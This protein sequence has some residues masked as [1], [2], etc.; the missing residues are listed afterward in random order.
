MAIACADNG[1]NT[2]R[3]TLLPR[4]FGVGSNEDAAEGGEDGA[5]GGMN[6]AVGAADAADMECVRFDLRCP[7]AEEEMGPWCW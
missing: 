6:D 7:H 5:G 3:R 2:P 4:W 1:D